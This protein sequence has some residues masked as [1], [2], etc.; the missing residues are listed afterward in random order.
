MVTN[1]TRRDRL[2]RIH[3][4]VGVA[5]ES[6]LNKVRSVLENA[7]GELGWS[8]Q[9]IILRSRSHSSMCIWTTLNI[10][11][12]PGIREPGHI[13]GRFPGFNADFWMPRMASPATK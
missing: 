5:Y 8:S 12:D 3:A 11:F 2:F 10:P 9:T 6:D 4:E 7:V 13:I 1:M